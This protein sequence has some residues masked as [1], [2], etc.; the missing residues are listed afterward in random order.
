MVLPKHVA[1]CQQCFFT[2]CLSVVWYYRNMQPIVSNV[3]LQ[4][5]LVWSG[6]TETCSPL[7]A[8]FFFTNCLSVVWYYRNMQPVVSNFFSFYK[9]PYCGL[10][11]SKH[12]AHCQQFFFFL[13]TA[14]LSS[15]ITETCS[16]L[17]AMFFYKLPYCGL[18]LPKHVAY[19]Q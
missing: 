12:L 3:F 6:I 5:A 13:Q 7:L 10:V 18:V 4:T 11:L 14:L 1:H 2:N 15:C 8:M 17:L 9:L 19:C 16:P